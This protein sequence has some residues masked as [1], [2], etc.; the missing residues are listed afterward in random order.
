[1]FGVSSMKLTLEEDEQIT[2]IEGHL[3]D[4]SINRL[5]FRTSKNQNIQVGLTVGQSFEFKIPE[6]WSVTCF[7][8]GI[9]KSLLYLQLQ[10]SPQGYEQGRED[11]MDPEY[12]W[13]NYQVF[14][15]Q[16]EKRREILNIE[17]SPIEMSL[18]CIYIYC[19]ILY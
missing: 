7:N 3:G 4:K 12:S 6:G 19:I 16:V 10:L 14:L 13:Q 1:M 8:G 11:G 2:A 18:R 17:D 15:Y 9:G 5:L